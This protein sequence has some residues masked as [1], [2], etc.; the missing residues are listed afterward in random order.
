MH[1]KV[2]S[3]YKLVCQVHEVGRP[4]VQVA[5]M[6]QV[7]RRDFRQLI[8]LVSKRAQ[9]WTE[10]IDCNTILHANED[11]V[12]YWLD[13]GEN[14]HPIVCQLG[15][16]SPSALARA[17]RTVESWGYDEINLNCGCPSDRVIG[18]LEH[19][20]ILMKRPELV[21]DCVRNMIDAV[22]IP[23]TVK[24]RLGVDDQDSPE[25]TA[26]FVRT[27]AEGG[28]RHFIIH[29]R[30]VLL[31][32]LSPEQNRKVPPLMHD[33]VFC[34]CNEFPTLNFT[35]NGGIKT[36]DELY[37]VLDGAPPNLV[38]VMIGRAARDNP[39]EFCEVDRYVFGE[40]S[41]PNTASTRHAILTAYCNYLGQQH[42]PGGTVAGAHG[43]GPCVAA[44]KPALGVLSGLWGKGILASNIEKLC[45]DKAWRS[46]GPG[47]ILRKVIILLEAD[48]RTARRLH[49]PLTL[50]GTRF[51]ERPSAVRRRCSD[52]TLPA[53]ESWDKRAEY[54]VV[55][56][57]V[58]VTVM[59]VLVSLK[60]VRGFKSAGRL[61]QA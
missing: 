7:T 32:G 47:A 14:E 24:C 42:P 34:L 60:R 45:R 59:L 18:K 23:V 43:P 22:N 35:L 38:G 51:P 48:E 36:L 49:Q 27:V 39:C 20:A 9:V 33:R 26:N 8:R 52:F 12:K 28:V 6:M 55:L 56:L 19:G 30:K 46:Q 29:A 16:N 4:L 13:F 15:G 61:Q 31:E 58:L 11:T 5:P 54:V 21:R 53:L 25:F 2:G 50:A 37:Q 40:P 1:H 3:R 44:L 41:N 10:M 57:V 17:A